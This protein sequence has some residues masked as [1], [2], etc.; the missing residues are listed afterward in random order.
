MRAVE[1]KN[2]VFSCFFSPSSCACAYV[3]V[4]QASS[5]FTKN[6]DKVACK[7]TQ[8]V[9]LQVLLGKILMWFEICSNITDVC[10]S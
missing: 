8:A 2:F 1:L 7:V 4:A 10:Q 5:H 3:G 9:E 6:G